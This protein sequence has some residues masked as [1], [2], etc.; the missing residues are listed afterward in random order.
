[1]IF[2][3]A[4]TVTNDTCAEGFTFTNTATGKECLQLNEGKEKAAAF[5]ET[6]RYAAMLGATTEWK[7]EEGITFNPEGNKLYVA[8]SVVGSLMSDDRW[9][10]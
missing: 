4:G 10:Y 2:L 6:R 1:M 5:L 9:R 7:K 3:Q 8:M